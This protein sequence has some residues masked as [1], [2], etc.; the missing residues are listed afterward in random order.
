MPL[1]SYGFPFYLNVVCHI[2]LTLRVQWISILISCCCQPDCIHLYRRCS[3]LHREQAED[4]MTAAVRKKDEEQTISLKCRTGVLMTGC[5]LKTESACLA[6]AC[7]TAGGRL[8]LLHKYADIVMCM[9]F[10]LLSTSRE[11][12]IFVQKRFLSEIRGF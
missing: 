6:P 8:S 3:W 11:S 7:D 9:H 10:Y 1:P 4:K 2:F 12:C 5:G